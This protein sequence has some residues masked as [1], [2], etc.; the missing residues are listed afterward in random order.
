MNLNLDDL[1]RHYDSLTDEA[2]LE[3]N[4]DDLTV[5]AREVLEKE[6]NTRNLLEPEASSAEDT[7]AEELP[8]TDDAN[9][10]PEQLVSIVTFTSP[11]DARLA[12]ALLRSAEI[13]CGLD[14]PKYSPDINLMVPA[15]FVDQATE[16]LNTE[17]SDEDLAAQAEA[18]G[19]EEDLP[20]GPEDKD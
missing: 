1:R 20:E 3:I 19:E 18:A 12:V 7:P 16:V 8:Q 2:L 5:A 11:T 15:S 14:Q 10:A 17:I 4:P 6:L 9:H 13:P